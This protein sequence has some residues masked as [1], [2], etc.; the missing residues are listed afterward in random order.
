MIENSPSTLYKLI[1]R[2]TVSLKLTNNKE[3]QEKITERIDAMSR[4]VIKILENNKQ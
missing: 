3:K 1:G 4:A 2:E